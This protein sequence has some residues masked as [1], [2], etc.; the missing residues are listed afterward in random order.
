MEAA[1]PGAVGIISS[2][3]GESLFTIFVAAYLVY[4]GKSLTGPYPKDVL[5]V[6]IVS[7]SASS[8]AA[9]QSSSRNMR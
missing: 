2:Y 6:P 9:S 5:E 4:I 8:Q 1:G 3:H 7:T